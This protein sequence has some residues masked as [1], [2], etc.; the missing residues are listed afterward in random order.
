LKT[1]KCR[2]KHLTFKMIFCG[3]R[4]SFG[5]AELPSVGSFA[6]LPTPLCGSGQAPE[7]KQACLTMMTCV[8]QSP[9]SQTKQSIAIKPLKKVS[10]CDKLNQDILA[11]SRLCR[12]RLSGQ[13]NASAIWR[14]STKKLYVVITFS[15]SNTH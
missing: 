1:S 7:T 5:F 9:F 10:K 15:R 3:F 12:D 2:I 8:T 13:A 4:L 11:R 14:I 6:C